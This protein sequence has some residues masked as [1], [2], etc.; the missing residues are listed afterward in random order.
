VLGVAVT[1]L[2]TL[3]GCSGGN[4][5]NKSAKS[6]GEP[7]QVIK[8]KFGCAAS[9]GSFLDQQNKEF[10]ELVKEKSGGRLDVA[11]FPDA[12][13]GSEP[14]N[15]E[16]LQTGT[17]ELAGLASSLPAVI[18]ELN[19]FDL[20]YLIT[21]R[22]QV[23]K[24]LA[25]DLYKEVQKKAE[26]KGIV[27]LGLGENGFRHITNNVRPINIPADLAGLKIRTPNNPARLATFKMLNANPTPIPFSELFQ[28]LQQGVVDGQENPL[29]QI[30]GSK[31]YEV[32][33]YLSLS[34]HVYTPTYFCASKAWYDKLPSD[35]Q[36][37]LVDAAMEAGLRGRTE[38]KELDQKLAEE[39]K[40]NGMVI[41]EVDVAAFQAA[42]K[43]LW[44]E[45]AEDIGPEFVD[46]FIQVVGD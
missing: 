20:P 30:T 14:A 11:Y 43:P 24:F 19:V 2:F 22:E 35:L 7:A 27:I 18:P 31:L 17:L 29:A 23:D 13:L 12:Q 21:E 5:A 3:I 45:L 39:C 8:P 4:S 42:M 6:G 28:A 40:A 32:Q 34:S 46:R 25:S 38:G 41:N 16:S 36:Q 9:S 10:M 26:D 44:S 37:A 15:Q 1:L 33:K